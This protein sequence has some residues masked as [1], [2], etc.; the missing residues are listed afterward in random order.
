MPARNPVRDILNMKK[1]HY[2]GDRE[3]KGSTRERR[4]AAVEHEY[5]G[6]ESLPSL[7]VLLCH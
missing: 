4:Y 3:A 1:I 2:S 7:V 6:G 5:E